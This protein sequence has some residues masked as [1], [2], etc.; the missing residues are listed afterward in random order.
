MLALYSLAWSWAVCSQCGLSAST[1]CRC[2]TKVWMLWN[3][4]DVLGTLPSMDKEIHWPELSVH[5]CFLTYRLRCGR[6][7]SCVL[8]SHALLT[9]VPL[10]WF[11]SFSSQRISSAVNHEYTKLTYGHR[12][13]QRPHFL[14]ENRQCQSSELNQTGG[15]R[16]RIDVLPLIFKQE[17]KHSIK[18][19]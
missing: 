15:L 5:W 1:G 2:R 3:C 17:M 9:Y 10:P 12:S 4:G 7:S 14:K 8:S 11:G 16:S 19:Y 18:V 6:V 13:C